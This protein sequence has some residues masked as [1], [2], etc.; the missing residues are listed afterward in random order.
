M[1]IIHY[2]KVA[3]HFWCWERAFWIALFHDGIE[4]GWYRNI[5]IAR[6]IHP[7]GRYSYFSLA[8]LA[9]TRSPNE[10]YADY[11]KRIKFNGGDIQRVKIADLLEN[12][13]RSTP[14]LRRRYAKALL[15]LAD[16]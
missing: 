10:T 2:V 8:L 1:K 6:K 15:V 4:D 7:A 3:R 5:C 11:I 13:K 12:Y 16:I 14:S 9:L